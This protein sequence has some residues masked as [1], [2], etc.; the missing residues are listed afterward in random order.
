MAKNKMSL[1]SGAAARVR[2]R[3]K[4]LLICTGTITLC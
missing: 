2:F 1:G 4:C 3:D